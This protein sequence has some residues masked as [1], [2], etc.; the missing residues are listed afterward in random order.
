PSIIKKIIG[1]QDERDG[2]C[3]PESNNPDSICWI[4][5]NT[6]IEISIQE[7]GGCGTSTLDYCEI[8]YTLDGGAPILVIHKDFKE[9]ELSWIYKMRFEEDSKHVLNVTCKDVAGNIL[10]D[11]EVFKVDSTPPKT[12]KTYGD[13][14]YPLIITETNYPH[15]ITTHTPVTMI[16]EDGGNICAIGVNKTYYRNYGDMCTRVDDK[17]CADYETCMTWPQNDEDELDWLVYDGTF[18]KNDESCHVI[19]FF[20]V[21]NLGNKEDTKWQCVYVEDTP[22]NGELIIGDPSIECDPINESDCHWVRDHVTEIDLSC[23]DSKPHPVNNEEV[24]FRISFDISP[25][26][27]K[28]YCDISKGIMQGPAESDWCCV[29]N[30]KLTIIF[31]EDSLHD[32]EYYCV[33]ALKNRNIVDLEYF[34]VD[35][36]PPIIEKTLIGPQ[37]GQCPPRPGTDD[38]CWIKDWTEMGGEGTTIHIEAYDNDTYENCTVGK[39]T[40]DWW[41]LLDGVEKKGEYGLESP[42]DIRFYE[43]TE[44]ELHIECRDALGN[45]VTDVETFRVDSAAPITKKWYTGVQYPEEGYPKWI[46]TET[47]VWLEAIDY[48]EKKICAV[49]VNETYWRNTMVDDTACWD[50]A[51]CQERIGKGEFT[52]YTGPFVKDEESCHLIEYFSVDLLGNEEEIKKQCVFIDN[53]TPE[54]DKDNGDAIKD[55]GESNFTNTENPNGNFHW[56]S[57]EM[58]IVFTCTDQEPHPSENERVCFKVSYDYPDWGYITEKY[59]DDDLTEDGYCCVSATP[60]DPYA[61]YFMEDS[62]H[63]LEYYCVDIVNQTSIEY[64]Q[65]YKVDTAVPDVSKELNGPYH[66]ECPPRPGT[67]DE[68]FV[69]TATNITLEIKDNGPI[70]AVG[71]VTCKWKYREDDGEGYGDW[72]KWNYKMPIYFPEE[73]HHELYIECSDAL[74]NTWEDTEFFSVDKTPPITHKKYI[75]PFFQEVIDG[76]EWI[77]LATYVSFCVEDAGPHKSGINKTLYRVT[78]DLDNKY[79]VDQRACD[80]AVSNEDW[81]E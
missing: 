21:D 41:Y 31:E 47:Q 40:C 51:I 50:T 8:T 25:W 32:L 59:C 4:T 15:W 37:V 33:D 7:E 66:G 34:R 58:P 55:T 28:Y 56:I 42:F 20:S 79:C 68:C 76:P 35:S 73:S 2:S 67:D 17:Y 24:C 5:D 72:S 62:M 45:S 36:N 61:F 39:V 1:T 6:Q 29:K 57:Q 60:K 44:H 19:E 27:T 9:G 43:D 11:I 54:V 63:N 12:D 26:L 69:D 48:P 18:T 23:I 49:G 74:G 16:A 3:P 53:T 80:S 81:I 71:N 13:P 22:P 14:H 46:N 65:Y 78:K 77:S 10:G 38:K 52:N 70:C 64:I 30:D 75:G